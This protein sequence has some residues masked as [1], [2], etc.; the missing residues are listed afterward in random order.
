MSKASDNEEFVREIQARLGLRA[1]GWAGDVTREAAY[2][3]IPAVQGVARHTLKDPA[4]FFAA[5]KAVTGGLTQGQ[6]DGFNALLAAMSGWPVSWAAYGLATAFHET[7]ATMQP[8][9]EMGGNAYFHRMYDK[10]GARPEVAKRLGNTQPGD[11]VRYAG[12]GYVQL[13]GRANYAKYGIENDPDAAMDPA[14]AA[15]ILVDG[16]SNGTFTGRKLANYLPG[17]YVGA[18]RVINGTDKAAK[19]AGHAE[20]FEAA[21]KAG[22][23]S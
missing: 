23:W 2:A 6:V 12:R 3:K 1:D 15:A 5:V 7:A 18:R 8:I 22:G 20:K 19:I 21:L 13:T 9:K 4:A 10:D 14:V 11:G 17:G 16:M